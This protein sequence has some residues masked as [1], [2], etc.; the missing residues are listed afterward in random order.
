ML[1][2]NVAGLLGDGRTVILHRGLT[3]AV[4]SG[5]LKY[6]VTANDLKIFSRTS[7]RSYVSYLT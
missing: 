4:A 3:E 1:D 2:W 6:G 7:T 5:W